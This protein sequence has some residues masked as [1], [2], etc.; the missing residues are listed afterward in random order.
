MTRRTTVVTR[1]SER[2]RRRRVR[3]QQ[4]DALN[5]RFLLFDPLTGEPVAEQ[6]KDMAWLEAH[7]DDPGLPEDIK[8]DLFMERYVKR[9]RP[10]TR[11]PRVFR[12]RRPDVEL[13]LVRNLY[14]MLVLR[15]GALSEKAFVLCV[16]AVYRR[17]GRLTAAAVNRAAQAAR[18]K[19]GYD[20]EGGL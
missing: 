7:K 11:Y 3:A 20:A 15:D 19:L 14:K 17:N 6:E 4:D 12:H 8:C 16:D 1:G 2:R 10:F 18:R 13:S 5:S 9:V